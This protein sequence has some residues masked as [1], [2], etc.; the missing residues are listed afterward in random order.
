MRE[1]SRRRFVYGTGAT[2]AAG[3]LAGCSGN[4]GGN[5]NG[6]SSG[7]GDGDGGSGGP[8]GRVDTFLSDNSANAYDGSVE[9]LTGQGEAT[10]SVG[11]GD[12]G[13][14]FEPAAIRVDSGTTVV[15]EWTGNGGGHN[16]VPSDGSDFT[17]FGDEEVVDSSDRTV[18][19][20]F[21][22]AGVA[23]YNCQPHRA[24]GMYGA[25]IVE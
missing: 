23:F 25:I 14:A 8:E 7:N 22:E 4:G 3:A 17:D 11:G 12:N 19:S 18:E 5:G 6:D 20:T 16:V 24:Q 21:D 13:F 10:V 9:D 1:L 2:I 15:F